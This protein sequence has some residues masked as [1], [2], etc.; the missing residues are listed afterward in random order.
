MILVHINQSHS[1]FILISENV[2]D[3]VTGKSRSGRA[4]KKK[5]WDKEDF[6]F[7]NKDVCLVPP[8][9]LQTC[10]TIHY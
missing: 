3:E 6:D 4:I 8:L 1:S 2:E 7:S 10:L 5:K 9:L